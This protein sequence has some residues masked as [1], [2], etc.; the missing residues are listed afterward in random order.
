LETTVNLV[1]S[2]FRLS[3]LFLVSSL[4]LERN[5]SAF[6]S[7]ALKQKH[8]SNSMAN[9]H[10]IHIYSATCQALNDSQNRTDNTANTKP[11]DGPIQIQFN[12]LTN[13]TIYIV[14]T[15][16]NIILLL[17]RGTIQRYRTCPNFPTCTHPQDTHTAR[18]KAQQAHPHNIYVCVIL[19]IPYLSHSHL[20]LHNFLMTLISNARNVWCCNVLLDIFKY[21]EQKK[22]SFT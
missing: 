7:G 12:S 17:P 6:F 18:T 2:L 3:S 16:L 10:S 9:D 5:L 21:K 1:G 22:Y 13:L 4:K 11:T 14:Q 8:N 19:F 15:Y 20:C